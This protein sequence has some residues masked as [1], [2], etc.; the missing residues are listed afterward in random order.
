[1][2]LNPESLLGNLLGVFGPPAGE[3]GKLSAPQWDVLVLLV[4][5][6]AVFVYGLSVGRGRMLVT[7]I[8]T[9]IALAVWRVLPFVADLTKG[10]AREEAFWINSAAFLG[11]V[12]LLYFLL[13]RTAFRTSTRGRKAGGEWLQIFLISALQVGLLVSVVL[14]F[15][16]P[17]PPFD[18]APIT[19]TLFTSKHAAFWWTLIPIAGLLVLRRRSVTG[20][21]E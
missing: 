20:S 2:N 7:L 15:L 4:F 8:S 13:S 19:K 9:Y 6:V 10:K 21:H 11:L 16:P 12:V 5:V 1:M 14:S 3:A 18:L 17:K